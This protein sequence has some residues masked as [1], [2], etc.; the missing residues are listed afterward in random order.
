MRIGQ[1]A[2]GFGVTVFAVA[3]SAAAWG[4]QVPV[5]DVSRLAVPPDVLAATIS[6]LLAGRTG[7]VDVWVQLQDSSLGAAHADAK[8]AGSPLTRDAQRAWLAELSDRHDALSRVAV[9]LGG[10]E[11]ARVSKAHNA[12][13][14]SIDARNLAALAA[15]P[16]VLTIR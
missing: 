4:Q 16:G 3:I 7:Q 5:P 1:R 13:A 10:R 6:P 11:L 9:S 12:V 15:Q 2:T 14:F 8:A